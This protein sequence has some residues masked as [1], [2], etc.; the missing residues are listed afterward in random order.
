MLQAG[1]LAHWLSV[2]GSFILRSLQRG[3]KKKR[4]GEKDRD[5]VCVR[6]TEIQ[7]YRETVRDNEKKGDKRME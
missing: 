1:K 4:E 7:R 6:E 5:R 3:R 2:G